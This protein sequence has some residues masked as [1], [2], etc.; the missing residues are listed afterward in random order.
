M[1]LAGYIGVGGAPKNDGGVSVAMTAR[2]VTEKS[3]GEAGTPI[4]MT[5][6]VL[7]DNS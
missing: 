3:G 7:M 6:P 4:A 2:M 1:T 5:A